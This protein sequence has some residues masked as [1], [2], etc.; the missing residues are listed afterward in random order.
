M[1]AELAI[2]HDSTQHSM[3]ELLDCFQDNDAQPLGTEKQTKRKGAQLAF[4]RGISL[5][6]DRNID[7]DPEGLDSGSSND[8]EDKH[9]NLKLIIPESKRKTMVDRFQEALGAASTSDEGHLIALPSHSS[10]G[11][12]GKLQ[13]VMQREKERDVDFSNRLLMEDKEKSMDV[14]I[15]SRCLEAKLTVC[16]CSRIGNNEGTQSVD[17]HHMMKETGERTLTIIFSSRICSDVE[18][19]VG[20]LI[21]VY[22][23]WR[24]VNV[25]GKEGS[26]ILS[27]YFSEL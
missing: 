2:R 20:K 6:G 24:E 11:L 21:R 18:L 1:T 16:S 8:D 10:I 23:P 27:A 12:F 3:V 26:T 14:E 25:M 22:P 15:L 5:L 13:Q 19:E 4:K 9:Q 17:N 7:D